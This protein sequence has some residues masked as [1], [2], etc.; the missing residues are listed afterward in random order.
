MPP[1]IILSSCD[2]NPIDRNHYSVSNMFLLAGAKTVLGSA[3]SIQSHESSVYISRLLIRLSVFLHTHL[4]THK[5]SIRWSTFITGMIRQSY[6]TE[7]LFKLRDKKLI[8]NEQI[9]ELNF[10]INININPLALDFHNII[11][12][13]VRSKANLTLNELNKFI[14]DNHKMAECLKYIQMGN[15]E[16]LIIIP[17]DSK[18]IYK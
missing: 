9:E 2:T 17:D 16:N 4:I 15:P 1:I 8:K 3:L 12:K 13:E 6:Y 5:Q 11:Y 18:L 7:L 10:F 14:E